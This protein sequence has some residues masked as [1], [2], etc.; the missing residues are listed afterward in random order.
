MS[1]AIVFLPLSQGKTAVIDFEDFEK[2]RGFKYHYSTRGYAARNFPVQAPGRRQTRSYL[3]HDIFGKVEAGLEIDHW[4][5]N[6]LNNRR[7]NLRAVTHIQNMAN[8]GTRRN[9]KS[10]FSGVSW[11][12]RAGKWLARVKLNGQSA[13]VGYF[14][15]AEEAAR[16]YDSKAKELFG[17]FARLNFPEIKN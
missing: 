9:S 4:D 6:K 8:Q 14:N 13:H 11:S 5:R 16:A 10:G 2:V 7:A 15:N 12:S 1:E 3:H 17:E